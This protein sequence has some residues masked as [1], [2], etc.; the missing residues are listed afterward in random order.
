MI[1]VGYS[2]SPK[3]RCYAFN[4]AIPKCAFD[5]KILKVEVGRSPS[6]NCKIAEEGENAMK[7]SL[8]RAGAEPLGYEFFLANDM[9]IEGAWLAGHQAVGNALSGEV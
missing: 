5:W 1:K 9:Q 3:T 4:K 8:Q 7:Y 6:L 2:G